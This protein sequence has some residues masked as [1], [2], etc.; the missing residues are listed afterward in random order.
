VTKEGRAMDSGYYAAMTGL[1]ARTQAMDIAASNLSNA[2]TP[3]YRA[4]QEYFRSVLLGPDAEDSQ[5]GRTVNNY[6]LLGGDRLNLGQGAIQQTGNPLDLAIEGEG[7]FRMQTPNGPRYTRDGGFHRT[8]AGQLATVSGD[9]VLSSTGQVIP[10]PPGQVSVGV[11]GAISV[12]GGVVATV[13]VFTFPKGAQLSPE[14]INRYLAPEGVAP[15]L[16]KNA[17]VHQGAI[18]SA[19]QGT[20]PGSLNLLLIQRETEMM[21]KALTV[22]HNEFN[23][24]AAEELPKV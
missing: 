1:V 16:S 24:I 12:A 19:N 6:G 20:I 21:Q 2:S 10:I 18:E 8:P 22:F 4:E 9:A 5:L 11:D 15:T 14:G 23:K 3:G 17:T 7:F 13:G